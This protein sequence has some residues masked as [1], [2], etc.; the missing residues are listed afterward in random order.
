[1]TNFSVVKCCRIS[2]YNTWSGKPHV[3]VRLTFT[4]R[5]QGGV[6][7]S[8]P[9]L[10]WWAT[11]SRIHHV[12][13]N[14]SQI[15]YMMQCL[16]DKNTATN[17][18]KIEHIWESAL[19]RKRKGKKSPTMANQNFFLNTSVGFLQNFAT[20]LCGYG[21]SVCRMAAIYSISACV[22]WD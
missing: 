18:L 13:L 1:M 9:V 2:S 7:L 19:E 14:W 15:L 6:K 21:M 4:F 11:G 16:P 10:V 17:M 22:R 20:G 8:C 12:D 5:H 3:K